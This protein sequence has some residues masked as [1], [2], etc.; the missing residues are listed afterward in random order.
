ME[1][2]ASRR[3]T[4]LET[5]QFEFGYD[6]LQECYFNYPVLGIVTVGMM[7]L[8]WQHVLV[9]LI[10]FGSERAIK[11]NTPFVCDMRGVSGVWSAYAGYLIGSWFRG[12]GVAY[13]I[14]GGMPALTHIAWGLNAVNLYAHVMPVVLGFLLAIVLP[15]FP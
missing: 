8:G 12:K 6:H 2:I 10:M 14:M 7:S 5:I 15:K 11:L 9:G 3:L 13:L 1:D 4:W